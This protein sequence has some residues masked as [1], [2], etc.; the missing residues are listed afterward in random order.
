MKYSSN[1]SNLPSAVV[2]GLSPTGLS[3]ARSLSPR[4]VEVYG[5]D[6]LRWEI[7]HFSRWIKHDSRISYLPAGRALL[8]AMI[9]FGQRQSL[10]PV[11]FNAGD[12]YIDFIAE[13]CKV[14]ESYFILTDSMCPE[15]NS[16]FLNK[17]SFYEK[18]LS[19]DIALP[20]TFFPENIEDVNK[21]SQKIRYPAIVK[22]VHGHLTRNLLRGKKLIEVTSEKELIDWWA[23]LKQK[24][25]DS[26]LQ[27]VIEGPESNIAVAGI[28]MDSKHCCKSLFTARKVR[29]YPPIYGS[30]SY[31][32]SEWMPDIADLSI[33]ILE[34]LKY[35]GIC[36]T[37]FKWDRI[38]SKW[39][40]IEINCRPTL[41]FALT[42]ASGVDVVWDAYCD[43]IGY[44]ND[45]H[46]CTQKDGIRWQLLIRD[47]VSSLYFLRKKELSIKDF[48][49]TVLSPCNKVEGI[50]S[51]RDWKANFGYIVNTGMQYYNHFLK[52]DKKCIGSNRKVLK[53]ELTG[54]QLK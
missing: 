1:N 18:C 16:V 30:G 47:L 48:I 2:L 13:N 41:W 43:L 28:Y 45:I 4:G 21:I 29:Q 3:V 37:E 11:I 46:I 9:E 17:K 32:E 39:K 49:H 22:P 42:R 19:I 15:A 50:L 26:V 23:K 33:D 38:D 44:P 5:I 27:E 7:G 52:K 54:S 6:N 24:D 53:S 8:D 51:L 10:K 36:G 12:P 34:K 14:L 40:L 25:S 20:R 31:M 35:H